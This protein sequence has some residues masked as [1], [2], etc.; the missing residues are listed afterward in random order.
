MRDARGTIAGLLLAL[1]GLFAVAA[2]SWA[3]TGETEYEAALDGLFAELAVS[4][5]PA[6]AQGIADDIWRLWME[7]P[8]AEL[9][10]RMAATLDLRWRGDMAGLIATLDGIIADH[11]DYAEAYNQRATVN[12][13]LGNYERSL[14]DIAETL[15]REPRHFGAL[16]GR[17][18][19]LKEQGED[20]RALADMR[21][22]LKIH[23]FLSER[24]LFPELS[25]DAIEA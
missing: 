12:F 3:Q 1:L 9:A 2:P 10:A 13:M 15:A 19:I 20:Q 16:A 24:T 5:D 22:A 23:P 14:A 18:L 8:D 4:P 21:A 17:A 11:P 25:E 7:P 6:T